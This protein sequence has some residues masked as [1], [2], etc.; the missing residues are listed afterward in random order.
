M[1]EWSAGGSGLVS[2]NFS[3]YSAP[4]S[5]DTYISKLLS[6]TPNW[7][8]HRQFPHGYY[9]FKQLY[10]PY[11]FADYPESLNVAKTYRAHAFDGAMYARLR[12][13]FIGRDEKRFRKIMLL[14]EDARHRNIENLSGV[15]AALTRKGFESY[16]P[17]LFDIIEQAGTFNSS[18]LIAG[19]H[20]ASLAN[21]VW[22]EP[23]ASVIEMIPYDH[24]DFGY[25][26]ICNANSVQHELIFCDS[27]PSESNRKK[28]AG[29]RDIAV[30]LGILEKALK[31]A[32]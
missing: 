7:N 19:V 12:E 23:G 29:Y 8:N 13:R 27:E 15:R 25:S 30:D 14:R 9:E 32:Q 1:I 21:L 31:V 5:P 20:G 24:Q 3:F 10:V 2:R 26:G 11:F 17:A 16:S 28:A 18:R 4:I 6:L 22:C